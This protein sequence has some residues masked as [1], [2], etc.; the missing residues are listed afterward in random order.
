MLTKRLIGFMLFLFGIGITGV[1]YYSIFVS[2][3]PIRV[4]ASC[5]VDQIDQSLL[6]GS[7]GNRKNVLVQVCMNVK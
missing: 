3:R 7:N 2:T 1:L 4:K 6:L 5:S